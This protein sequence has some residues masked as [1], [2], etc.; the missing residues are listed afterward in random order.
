MM[1][2]HPID[3]YV[4]HEFDK[5]GSD[6]TIGMVYIYDRGLDLWELELQ[7]LDEDVLSRK[8]FIGEIRQ[9]YLKLQKVRS[10]YKELLFMTAGQTVYFSPDGGTIRS[11]I[12][13]QT[14]YTVMRDLALHSMEMANYIDDFDSPGNDSPVRVDHGE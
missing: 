13:N 9:N 14:C 5:P 12:S 3:E 10:A 1:K 4:K 8:Y 2:D 7:R 11:I 6:S